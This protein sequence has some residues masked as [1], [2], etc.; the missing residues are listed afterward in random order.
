MTRINYRYSP[1]IFT[2]VFLETGEAMERAAQAAVK[3]AGEQAKAQG[4]SHIL[5]AGL[6]TRFA[7]ALRLN[8]YPKK[9]T[10]LRAAAQI[11]HKIPYAGVF[12]EGATIWGKPRLWLP[13]PST[14][15]KYGRYRLTPERYAKAIGPLQYVKRPGKAPL[16][17]AK[18][19]TTKS[20][21][22]AKPSLSRL[23]AGARGQGATT[24]VPLFVGIDSVSIRKRLDITGIVRKARDR[25]AEFYTENMRSE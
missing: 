21:K 5:S 7:N 16:L 15:Q 17:F 14:P 23:K 22:P 10:S 6:G 3:A 18:V 9:G 1:G 12:E 13:L 25:L 20:G 8:V 2:R 24:S 4:R 19:K 11:Y